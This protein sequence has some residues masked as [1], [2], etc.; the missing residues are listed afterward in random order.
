[1]RTTGPGRCS[2][3][4][5]VT[6]LRIGQKKKPVDSARSAATAT[7]WRMIQRAIRIVAVSLPWGSGASAISI[8]ACAGLRTARGGRHPAEEG[9]ARPPMDGPSHRIPDRCGPVQGR[10]HTTGDP[11]DAPSSAA[12]GGPAGRSRRV[13]DANEK[14][15]VFVTR[16][17][18][19]A[20]LDRLR[21]AALVEVWPG[22]GGPPREALLAA[23]ADADGVLCL[24]TD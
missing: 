18:P 6:V 17:L 16:P 8:L 23:V 5:V 21:E 10:I 14:P 15:R 20:G 13:A 12:A 22:P 7:R 1:M 11:R 24:L 3:N 4:A 2:P 9:G 19:G